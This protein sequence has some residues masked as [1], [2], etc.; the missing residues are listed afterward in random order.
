MTQEIIYVRSYIAHE[1]N[2][3]DDILLS[4]SEAMCDARYG[5]IRK[6][7]RDGYT[8]FKYC[9][10]HTRAKIEPAFGIP[11]EHWKSLKAP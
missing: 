2:Y 11:K 7:R 8:Y 4:Q 5:A 6:P 10:A 9:H 1:I 3:L